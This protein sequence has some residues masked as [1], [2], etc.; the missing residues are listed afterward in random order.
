MAVSVHR[1]P[2]RGLASPL[3]PPGSSSAHLPHSAPPAGRTPPRGDPRATGRRVPGACAHIVEHRCERDPGCR[4]RA[5]ARSEFAEAQ[6]ATPPRDTRPSP[7]APR[8]SPSGDVRTPGGNAAPLIDD[9]KLTAEW[10]RHS[11]V[12]FR[13]VAPPPAVECRKV[14]T[15]YEQPGR[16]PMP[17]DAQ[18]S[19]RAILPVEGRTR[20][21]DHTRSSDAP[22]PSARTRYTRPPRARCPEGVVDRS[23]AS[24]AHADQQV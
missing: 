17:T 8:P 24:T 4:R 10:H 14:T 2:P 23:I 5:Q 19:R 13:Q 18:H 9:H 21:M 11:T 20:D 22:E 7:A 15:P 6:R 16:F 12:S 1:A 3:R